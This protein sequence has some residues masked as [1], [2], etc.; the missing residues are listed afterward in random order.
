MYITLKELAVEFGIDRSNMRKYVLKSGFA[1]VSIRDQISRQEVLALTNEEA[2]VLRSQRLR[3]GY[4][5][6]S[7]SISSLEMGDGYS[8]VRIDGSAGF[9][10]VIQLV[11]ELDSLRVKLG[12]AG[13]TASRLADHRTAAPT[14]ALVKS[15]PCRKVWELAAM[16]SVTR[17]ECIL[18]GNEVYRCDDMERLIQRCED[19]FALMPAV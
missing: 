18:I 19:F 2:D 3:E 11:P 9:F 10:Y 1:P 14:A 16:Q 12:W 15:W 7:A 5:L 17:I 13:N 6:F 8:A 4:N